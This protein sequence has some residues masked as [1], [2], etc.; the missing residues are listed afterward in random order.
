MMLNLQHSPFLSISGNKQGLD[1]ANQD[2]HSLDHL[3]KSTVGELYWNNGMNSLGLVCGSSVSE[4][5]PTSLPS[6]V[7]PSKQ[8]CVCHIPNH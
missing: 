3:G 7:I 8:P 1:E 4:S 2:G 5:S 6:T